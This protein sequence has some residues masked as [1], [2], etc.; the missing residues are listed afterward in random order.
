MSLNEN[1]TA[2]R[3]CRG[4]GWYFPIKSE[5]RKV[6]DFTRE[7]VLKWMD[8]HQGADWIDILPV[9]VFHAVCGDIDIPWSTQASRQIWNELKDEIIAGDKSYAD[10]FK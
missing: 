5:L 9:K 8:S 7:N 3:I 10:S 6:S 2:D 1:E 4:C